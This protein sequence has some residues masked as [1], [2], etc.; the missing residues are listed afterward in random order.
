MN[1]LLY[2][3]DVRI[4]HYLKSLS[5]ELA[6]TGNNV[7]FM[8]TRSP[9]TVSPINEK[10]SYDLVLSN[11]DLKFRDDLYSETLG[12]RFQWMPDYLILARD[13]WFPEQ[14]LIDE[15]KKRFPS[16]KIV[17]VEVNSAYLGAIE[18]RMEMISK[19]KYPQNQVDIFLDHSTPILEARKESLPGWD[20]WDRSVVVGNPYWDN[21]EEQLTRVDECI[22]KYNVD[23]NKKQILFFSECNST[24]KL[25]LSILEKM[26]SELD[27]DKYQIY[28][29]PY[30]SEPVHSIHSKDYEID[31]NKVQFYLEDKLDGVVYNQVDLVAMSKICD[32][33]IGNIGSV[34]YGSFLFN[35]QVSTL[36][37][38][39]KFLDICNDIESFK[40]NIQEGGESWRSDFWMRVHKLDSIDEFVNLVG[41]DNVLN[42]KK[43]NEKIKNDLSYYCHLYDGTNNWLEAEKKDSKNMLKYYDDYGDSKSSIR[44]VEYLQRIHNDEVISVKDSFSRPDL[45]R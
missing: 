9:M 3:S 30:P 14:V 17:L 13:R 42:F 7:L 31:G 45:G 38:V 35:K 8:Y 44:I 20:G 41:L 2:G 22:K 33:H 18:I 10:N 27:R 43:R 26:L 1:C 11:P 23:I 24:R 29:K 36:H 19:L 37:T 25:V 5:T 16:V 21:V 39:T 12:I 28:F 32:Y 4:L 6:D 40:N 15:F 34:N